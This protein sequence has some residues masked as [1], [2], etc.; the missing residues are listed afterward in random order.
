MRRVPMSVMNPRRDAAVIGI[1]RDY[2][3]EVCAVRFQS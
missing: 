2:A 3:I 1:E